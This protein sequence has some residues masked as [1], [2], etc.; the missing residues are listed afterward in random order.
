MLI[1]LVKAFFV[2]GAI[3]ALAQILINFTKLTNGKILVL[4]IVAGC[5]LETF[6]WY[7]KLVEFAGAGAT[8]P[9][10]GFGSALTKGA[11]EATKEIGILGA[12]KG[13]LEATAFG[14]SVS[15]ICGYIVALISKPKTKKI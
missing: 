13:G 7:S 2:G 9:I 6:G 14:I 4:F 5:L 1:A 3:C 10:S 11:I 12:I 15:I 8:I